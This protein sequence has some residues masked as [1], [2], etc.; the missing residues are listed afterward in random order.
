MQF[1]KA[2]CFPADVIFGYFI[3]IRVKS[4]GNGMEQGLTAFFYKKM[5]W[6]EGLQVEWTNKPNPSD[7]GQRWVVT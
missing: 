4:T 3:D 6:E 2:N 5:S 7:L 1:L